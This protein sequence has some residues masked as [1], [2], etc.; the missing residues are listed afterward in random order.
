MGLLSAILNRQEPE[1]DPLLDTLAELIRIFGRHGWPLDGVSAEELSNRCEAW[2]KH[3]LLKL[4]PPLPQAPE[5]GHLALTDLAQFFLSRRR[6]EQ[7]YA[8]T[9][10]GELRGALVEIVGQ[11]KAGL[12]NQTQDD[13]QLRESL[14]SL[15]AAAESADPTELRAQV[16]RTV[17]SVTARL[18][19]RIKNQRTQL[20]TLERRLGELESDLEAARTKGASDPLTGLYNRGA[21]DTELIR[22]F[23]RA[24][25]TH[26]PLSLVLIDLDHFKQ[27]N[28]NHGHQTGDRVLKST[29]DALVR[30]FPRKS[31]VLARYGGEE[32]VVILAN[33][34]LKDAARLA[35]RFLVELKKEAFLV[36]QKALCLTAS[37]GVAQRGG[38]ESPEGLIARADKALYQAKNT[39]RDRVI[40]AG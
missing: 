31:D 19:S 25:R 37:A 27:I 5:E 9:V 15:L 14:T 38:H 6:S 10:V 2:A 33:T 7:A 20:D 13:Q 11:L 21:F 26:E 12:V 28:D 36:G 22:L 24:E 18:E 1:N 39:G 30:N 32:F 29:A 40:L 23:R 16:A 34:N 35:E 17:Q 3:L 4:P 8:Q